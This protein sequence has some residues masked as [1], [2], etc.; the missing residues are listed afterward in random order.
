MNSEYPKLSVCMITYNHEDF[1]AKAIEGVLMQKTN[2]KIE[3]IVADDCSKDNNQNRIRQFALE[4]SEIVKPILRDKNI[5]ANQNWIDAYNHCTGKYIALCEGDDYWTDPNKLQKQVDFLEAN[6]AYVLCSH[7]YKGIIV[8]TGEIVSDYGQELFSSGVESI[9]IGLYNYWKTWLTKTL[10]TVFRKDA[11]DIDILKKY[12]YARDS[13]IF[14]HILK[15]GKGICMNEFGGIYNIHDGGIHSSIDNVKKSLM[16]FKI[17]REL[18]FNNPED[19]SLNDAYI[20]SKLSFQKSI[21][22][23]IIIKRLPFLRIGVL[24]DLDEYTELNK[25]NKAFSY[26]RLFY[27]TVY[28][29]FASIHHKLF[30]IKKHKTQVYINK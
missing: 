23:N 29:L 26:T 19:I 14:Y 16:N 7:R 28:F 6:P 21:S 22:Q 13:H 4:N 30:R 11:F 12:S 25:E 20:N 15:N 17:I 5:G 2:F 9:E 8:K 10:T 24:K 1:I 18:Q 27:N 3:L